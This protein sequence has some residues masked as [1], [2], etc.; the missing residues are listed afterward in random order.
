M[1]N[2]ICFSGNGMSRR[3][4][5]EL[6]RLGVPADADSLGIVFPVY[7]WRTPKIL[8]RF[9]CTELA[10]RLAGRRPTYIWTVM[11]CGDD[12]GFTDRVLDQQLRQAIGKGLDAAFS[13]L[14]PD[15]YIGLPGFVLDEDA[16]AAAKVRATLDLLPTI[17]AKIA[18]RKRVC[19]LKRGVFPRTK[20]YLLGTFFNRFLVR[21]GFFRVDAAKCTRCGV[22]AKNCPCGTI[23]LG[24][25]GV[26][27]R[28][29][30]SCTGCLRCLHNCP[31]TAIEYGRFTRGKARLGG[32]GSGAVE[33]IG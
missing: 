15:T 33:F 10:A 26:T 18:A 31:V 30:G 8:A 21:A 7:G 32:G 12:V 27:W 25:T 4:A 23:E 19:E 5:D 9:I 22:C 28:R 13:V 29:D 2:L 14:M 11:T 3:V 6:C 20:T 17:A 24:K 16:E 1:S